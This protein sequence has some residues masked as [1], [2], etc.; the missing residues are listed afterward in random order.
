MTMH[1]EVHCKEKIKRDYRFEE[2]FLRVRLYFDQ[3]K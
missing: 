2:K 1:D 3:M